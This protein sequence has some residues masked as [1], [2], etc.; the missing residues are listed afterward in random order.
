MTS[1]DRLL[2]RVKKAQQQCDGADDPEERCPRR[3]Q[4]CTC[5]QVDLDHPTNALRQGRKEGE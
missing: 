5:W 1:L 4:D 2:A 3:P